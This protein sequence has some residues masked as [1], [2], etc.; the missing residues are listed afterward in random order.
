MFP[1]SCYQLFFVYL[2][3]QWIRY[4]HEGRSCATGSRHGTPKFSGVLHAPLFKMNPPSTISGSTTESSSWQ[5][6]LSRGDLSLWLCLGLWACTI[7]NCPQLLDLCSLVGTAHT[8]SVADHLVCGNSAV[9]Y[10]IASV[11]IEVQVLWCCLYADCFL[12]PWFD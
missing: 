1:S 11:V 7:A 8:G 3:L 2:E 10:V 6:R 4:M 12:T 9:E 5:M